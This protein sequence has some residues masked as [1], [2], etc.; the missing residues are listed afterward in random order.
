MS[1]ETIIDYET[2]HLQLATEAYWD[3]EEEL[4]LKTSG[5]G[6]TAALGLGESGGRTGIYRN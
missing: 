3:E 5:T 6:W 2:G 4:P 1:Y